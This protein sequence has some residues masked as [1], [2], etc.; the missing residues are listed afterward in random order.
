M[1]TAS[2]MAVDQ[3]TTDIRKATRVSSFAS[4]KVVLEFAS[5]PAV[6]Y[7][8]QQNPGKLTRQQQGKNRV[9][10]TGC[11]DL[12]FSIF[13]RTPIAG[14]YDQY[15]AATNTETKVVSINWSASRKLIAARSNQDQTYSA[16]VVL[17][18]R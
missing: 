5:A 8:Y 11:K 16:K 9:L 10:L 12:T 2:V 17:R 15:P 14:T 18:C 7:D 3:L 1:N 13:Q 6:H 4:N